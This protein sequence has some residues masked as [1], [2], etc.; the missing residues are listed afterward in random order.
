VLAALLFAPQLLAA[1]RVYV[2]VTPRPRPAQKSDAA[3]EVPEPPM[4][5]SHALPSQ[6]LKGLP[7]SQQQ[8]GVL[9]AELA[10]TRPVVADAK[11]KAAALA[12][13]AAALRKKLIDTAARIQALEREQALLALQITQLQQQDNALAA[14]FAQDR[15]SV[16]RLLAILER[17]QH[18]TPPALVV[19]PDDALAAAR[20]AMLVGA[21]L[22]PVYDRAAS[23]ARRIETLKATRA[24]LNS[25]R[26]DAA[27]NAASLAL[28]HSDLVALSAEKDREAAGA[29]D[30]YGGLAAKLDI[31]ARQA[32]DFTALVTRVNALRRAAGGA[33]EGSIVTVTA[34][35]SGSGGTL[36][37]ASLLEPVA[38]TPV[39]GGAQSDK[40]PGLTYATASGAQVIAPADGKVLFAGPYHKEGQVLILEITTGYDVVLSGLG[41]V[42]VRLGDELLAGEPVGI[43]PQDIAQ[44][45]LYFELRQN[46]KGLDPEPWLTKA[47]KT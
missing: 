23:L 43:M 31:V 6:S 13:Q 20:G 8:L 21:S 33:P 15:I 17:L 45:R 2:P 35:N 36:S 16:T 9:K 14:G 1:S 44:T 24:A 12:A 40:N 30:L 28:A 10:K 41:R 46:G 38:G 47:K 3:P 19:R 22:P 5:L 32:A 27:K 11:A 25:R 37:K 4:D 42:T 39:P 34:Q 29:A 18:D 7:S 26:L